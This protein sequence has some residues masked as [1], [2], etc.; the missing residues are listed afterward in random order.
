MAARSGSPN[1]TVSPTRA[2]SSAAKNR[3][4]SPGIVQFGSVP[5]ATDTSKLKLNSKGGVL[6]TQAEVANA[7]AFMDVDKSGK[8][9]FANLKKRLSVLFPDMSTKDYRFLMN[10]KRELTEADLMELLQENEVV[11]FDPVAEAF[12][13]YDTKG[14]GFID[15]SHLKEI[16]RQFGFGELS[17]EELE[18][19]IKAGDVDGDGK[20]SLEDFR[21]MLDPVKMAA[22]SNAIVSGGVGG[23]GM[24]A[25]IPEAGPESAANAN[26]SGGGK[27]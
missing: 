26:K 19:L 3:P 24:P 8:L 13:A 4:G 10:G 5:T 7:F 6:V 22:A 12:K 15:P 27:V 18:V 23:I 17:K 14:D 25:P 9:T 20:I 21:D 11:N 16:F 2:S 1:R